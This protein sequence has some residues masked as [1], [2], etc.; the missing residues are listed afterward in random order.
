V[1]H[2]LD[3]GNQDLIEKILHSN[4]HSSTL[5]TITTDKDLMSS[6]VN[7][8]IEFHEI[9][10]ITIIIEPVN[11]EQIAHHR[12]LYSRGYD[13][14]SIFLF[15][16]Q[17]KRR[18]VSINAITQFAHWNAQ[19][20]YI[21]L[22]KSSL[23]IQI[24]LLFCPLCDYE[25]IKIDVTSFANYE[26]G[27]K[28]ISLWKYWNGNMHRN[29]VRVYARGLSGHGEDV[30]KTRRDLQGKL[31][32]ALLVTENLSRV[33]NVTIST[34]PTWDWGKYS[35]FSEIYCDEM[36]V[37]AHPKYVNFLRNLTGN[38]LIFCIPSNKVLKESFSYWIWMAP[39]QIPVWI[40][41]VAS[42]L[43]APLLFRVSFKKMIPIGRRLY[44]GFVLAIR[45]DIQL[46]TLL[47]VILSL[48]AVL[49]S[50]CYETFITTAIVVPYE[51]VL[52]K[53]LPDVLN[54]GDKIGIM[55]YEPEGA[56]SNETLEI[57][58]LAM[59]V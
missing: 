58:K 43:F 42:F 23:E 56:N 31:D 17:R 7:P 32:R 21:L 53:N 41:I 19:F 2:L 47:H 38:V 59:E 18:R 55:K 9:C 36:N 8:I 22:K 13:E 50:T 46:S 37:D 12:M 30:S 39:F 45:Q 20:Y 14:N 15:I 35:S 11:I 34:H 44:M 25:E 29:L 27:M 5:W 48:A 57:M 16:C 26:I 6:T 1:V 49:F 4:Y 51:T 40:L 3:L 54:N 28:L 33:A 10:S 24:K 52:Y